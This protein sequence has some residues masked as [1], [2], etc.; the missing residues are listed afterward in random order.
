MSHRQHAI[1][2]A[3]HSAE[4]PEKLSSAEPMSSCLYKQLPRDVSH[5]VCHQ[6]ALAIPQVGVI[7]MYGVE[8]ADSR[9]TSDMHHDWM[10]VAALQNVCAETCIS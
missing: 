8:E 5:Q 3:S 2:R 10:L 7:V 9:H 1:V 6:Q 4:Q